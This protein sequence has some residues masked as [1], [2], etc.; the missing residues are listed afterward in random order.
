MVATSA[1]PWAEAGNVSDSDTHDR[2]TRAEGRFDWLSVL[3]ATWILGGVLVFVSAIDRGLT[4]DVG[5]SPYHVIFYSGILA[6]G[7]TCGAAIVSAVRAGDSWRH[8]FPRGYGS[9]GVGLVV[10]LAWP[11]VDIGWREGVGFNRDS[12][13]NFIAPSRLL[14]PIG[15]FLVA[16]GPLR[17]AMQPLG[18]TRRRG[19]IVAAA[20]LVFSLLG[21]GGF[22]PFDSPWLERAP[23]AP[24]TNSEIWVMDADGSHQTRLI[25][26]KDGYGYANAVWSPDGSRIAFGRFKAPDR[27]DVPSDDADIWVAKADG[28]DARPLVGGPG[29]QWLPH[30]SPDGLWIVYTVDPPGGPGHGAGVNAP[31]FGFGQ[32]PGFGQPGAVTP[33]VDVWR[34]RAD[35]TGSPERLTDAPSDDRAGVYSPDGRHMLFDSTRQQGRTGIYVMD[36]DGT[37]IVRL[38]F[39][40]DDWGGTWS[41]DGTRIAFNS[42]RGEA[43][44]DIYVTAF[45]AAGPPLQLT[46]D[47][48]GDTAPSWSTDGARLAFSGY[49]DGQQEIWSMAADGSDLQNLSRTGTAAEF[50]APGGGAWGPGNRI[51]YSRTPDSPA[52]NN[53]LVR[54]NLGVAGTLFGAIMFAIVVLVCVRLRAPFGTVAFTLAL[55]TLVVLIQN[56]EWRFLPAAI[57]GGLAVDVIIRLASPRWK[58]RAAGAASAAVIVLSAAATVVFTTGLG[59]TPTLLLGVAMMCAA[60]GWGLG[61]LIGRSFGP[62]LGPTLE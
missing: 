53:R 7:A 48:A 21:I 13:E 45:P 11:V 59:W 14:I 32:G 41:P 44:E 27:A 31:A 43:P 3:L 18:P 30:W 47:H 51:L 38:T 17:A 62:E 55:G 42:S 23:Y 49:R 1:G 24:E 25:E 39:L 4:G 34:V 58:A 46:H 20:G 16:V 29:W 6:L 50:L 26:A 52:S 12:I 35:G 10:L 2:E 5:L 54:E 61:S 40:G 22:Q 19:P 33:E 60:I 8:A 36:P 15:I 9:L 37:N 57:V 56:G 28:S